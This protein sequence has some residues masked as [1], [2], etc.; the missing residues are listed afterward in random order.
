M[1]DSN[2]ASLHS[3]IDTLEENQQSLTTLIKK[4]SANVEKLLSLTTPIPTIELTLEAQHQT[5]LQKVTSTNSVV[6]TIENKCH[7]SRAS[8]NEIKSK[9]CGETQT[10]TESQEHIKSEIVSLKN[11][12]NEKLG[13]IEE[14]KIAMNNL[15]DEATTAVRNLQTMKTPNDGDGKRNNPNN[16]DDFQRKDGRN[17]CNKK[18]MQIK[19]KSSTKSLVISDSIFQKLTDEMLDESCEIFSISGANTDDITKTIL[20]SEPN[21]EIKNVYIHVGV[22]D[23]KSG[24]KDDAK[25]KARQLIIAANQTYKNAICYVSGVLP[26]RNNKNRTNI[27]KYNDV[28][29]RICE[30]TA[31]VY[32]DLSESVTSKTSNRINNNLYRDDIHPNSS[33]A[34]ELSKVIKPLLCENHC[35]P[36]IKIEHTDITSSKGNKFQ[37]YAAKVDSLEEM[38]YVLSELYRGDETNKATS[39]MYAYKLD[40]DNK[41][42]SDCF[43]DR[44]HNAGAHIMNCIEQTSSTNIIV[45]VS[46]EYSCHI[47]GERWSIIN[48]LACE[49]INMVNPNKTQTYSHRSQTSSKPYFHANPRHGTGR[50]N[51]RTSRFQNN[52]YWYPRYQDERSA[53]FPQ[54]PRY[55]RNNYRQ[56]NRYSRQPHYFSGYNGY[57]D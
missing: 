3:R 40:K 32:I 9:V 36:E 18:V 20:D 54:Q 12:V 37:G 7:E 17:M 41:G 33:G 51:F 50:P 56:P 30:E 1:V 39:I 46:R 42:H 15:I 27:N 8:I 25:G 26:Q 2:V 19:A 5:V 57:N 53:P 45:A 47:F 43:D 34:K 11:D 24:P 44:E 35:V 10:D 55:Q 38:R 21:D 49:A 28:L 16:G 29:E 48:E 13:K 14:E 52:K 23:S 6:Q 4:I 31:A 22:N